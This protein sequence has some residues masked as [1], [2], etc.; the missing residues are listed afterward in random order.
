[1]SHTYHVANGFPTTPPLQITTNFGAL[2]DYLGKTMVICR[3]GASVAVVILA[4]ERYY[5]L[6]T[7]SEKFQHLHEA[8]KQISV[9]RTLITCVEEATGGRGGG[10]GPLQKLGQ[11]KA[12]RISPKFAEKIIITEVDETATLYIFY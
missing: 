11:G 4:Q 3:R 6:L 1:M 2:A 8:E 5:L 7:F 12:N 10:E 9:F